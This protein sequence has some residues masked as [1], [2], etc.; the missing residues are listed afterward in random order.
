[1]VVKHYQPPGNAPFP[2]ATLN[3]SMVAGSNM[4][5]TFE[6]R[7]TKAKKTND[8][9]KCEVN[10]IYTVLQTLFYLV[11]V[12]Y[13][14]YYHEKM[15]TLLHGPISLWWRASDK[16]PEG[17]R[18]F[19]RMSYTLE[20]VVTLVEHTGSGGVSGRLE[21]VHM[22][23]RLLQDPADAITERPVGTYP[24]LRAVAAEVAVSQPSTVLKVPVAWV[25]GVILPNVLN[26]IIFLYGIWVLN[27]G[28]LE[29]TGL[30]PRMRVDRP[31]GWFNPYML[32]ID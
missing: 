28:Q 22:C 13:R 25:Q 5:D 1:M 16:C 19:P 31:I 17:H 29:D 32:D 24:R 27:T 15:A 10:I 3:H 26:M 6:H 4:V 21:G 30:S 7:D 23:V 8:N 11:L 9:W 20:E 12:D 18:V 14:A 2:I